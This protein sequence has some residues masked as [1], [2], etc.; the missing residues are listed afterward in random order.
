MHQHRSSTL[1]WRWLTASL[2]AVTA[3]IHVAI[4]PEHLR[5]APYAGVLFIVLAGAALASA[6]LVLITRSHLVW[7]GA[8]ALSI[9]AMLGYLMSRSVG[10][11]LLTDDVGDWLNPLGVA[12]VLSEATVALIFAHTRRGL[13]GYRILTAT[14]R[15]YTVVPANPT[16]PAG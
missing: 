5:E 10:L 16:D 8:A 3:A 12:A 1:L 9:A 11:P 7:L 4:A 13:R 2:L 14:E 15:L 6:V